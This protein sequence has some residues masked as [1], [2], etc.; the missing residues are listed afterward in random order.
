MGR[1]AN[2]KWKNRRLRYIGEKSQIV[3]MAMMRLF[4]HHPK[5]SANQIWREI[6]GR[7]R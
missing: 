4:G 3:Q 1:A 2:R 5:F 6:L 7:P